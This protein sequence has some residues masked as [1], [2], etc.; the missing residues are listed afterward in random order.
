MVR[1]RGH[2]IELGV[3][4]GPGGLESGSALLSNGP[5]FRCGPRSR[6]L[7][8]PVAGASDTSQP[9]NRHWSVQRG[10]NNRPQGIGFSPCATLF[11]NPGKMMRNLQK[12]G[13][14]GDSGVA[15]VECE[16]HTNGGS[17]GSSFRVSH[18][19]ERGEGEVLPET[20]EHL[21]PHEA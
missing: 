6:N 3:R 18:Q 14:G 5:L 15:T 19:V 2:R 4:L 7:R 17:S 1:R 11:R 21:R 10:Y 9:V 16:S 8:I 12:S 13:R 20:I